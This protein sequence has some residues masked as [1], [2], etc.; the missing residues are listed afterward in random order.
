MAKLPWY[1]TIIEEESNDGLKFTIKFNKIWILY[2]K[3]K[4]ALH[5]IEY[6]IGRFIEFGF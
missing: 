4:I 5:Y 1:M 6:R 3:S 2:Q